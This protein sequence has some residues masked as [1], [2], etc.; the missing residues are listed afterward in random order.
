MGSISTTILG[1][2]LLI[3]SSFASMFIL[4]AQGQAL[5][6]SQKDGPFP[7]ASGLPE[8][9]NLTSKDPTTGEQFSLRAAV[10]DPDGVVNVSAEYWFGTGARTNSSM[11][12]LPNNQYSLWISIP[13]GSVEP[14]HY[15]F[16]ANDSLGNWNRSSESVV[17]VTDNDDPVFGSDYSDTDPSTGDDLDLL[18]EITDN[19]GVTAAAVEYWF[20]SGSHVNV[21]LSNIGGNLWGRTVVIAPAAES[22][23]YRFHAFD[24]ADN[25]A[26]TTVISIA[27]TD[28]DRPVFTDISLIS[29]VGTGDTVNIT[30]EISENIG[31]DDVSLEYWFGE[32]AHA[33]ETMIQGSDD[34]WYLL[35][36]AP[37]NALDDLNYTYHAVDLSDNYNYSGPYS[38]KVRDNDA[39]V[40]LNDMSDQ[41][42]TT[43]DPYDFEVKGR[44]NIGIA[45]ASASY[46][47]GSGNWTHVNLSD[48]MYENWT[49]TIV[50]P[51]GT[52]HPMEYFITLT[53]GSDN[54]VNS[55]AAFVPIADNDDPY[56]LEDATY[57]NAT[58]GEYFSFSVYI[59]DNIMVRSSFVEYWFGTGGHVIEPMVGMCQGPHL[60]F[61]IIPFNST[62]DLFYRFIFN[63][64]SNNT[65]VTSVKIVDVWDND[66][67]VF[68]PDMSGS[69][70][71]TGDEFP[72][73][74]TAMDNI[75][76]SGVAVEYGFGAGT[77]LNLSLSRTVG[78]GPWIGSIII[79]PNSL[80]KLR[81]RFHAED[82][83]GNHNMTGWF[84]RTVVDNDPPI[85]LLPSPIPKGTTGDMYK[86]TVEVSDNINI[87]EV[88]LE[89]WFGGGSR[90]NLSLAM[91]SGSVWTGQI[92]IPHTMERMKFTVHSWDTRGNKGEE[93]SGEVEIF[94]N[95]RP[96][97]VAENS[98]RKGTTGEIF[99]FRISAKDNIGIAMASVEYWIHMNDHRMIN[100][101]GTGTYQVTVGL[102]DN[103]TGI[104]HYIFHINDTSGNL[105]TS[106]EYSL[107]ITDNDPPVISDYHFEPD[108]AVMGG[109]IKISLNASDNIDVDTAV[110]FYR[111]GTGS[112]S[113]L[114]MER[115]EVQY[116]AFI[117][118]PDGIMMDL[119]L[120]MRITDRSGNGAETDWIN[121]KAEDR[122][123][124]SIENIDDVY[125]YLG[126][127]I[128][129]TAV[130]D[131]NHGVSRVTWVW[132]TSSHEGSVL[133][134]KPEGVINTTVVV[135]VFDLSGN[136]ASTGFGLIVWPVDRDA[137][138][139]GMP[140]LY[141]IRMG[142]DPW[143]ETDASGDPD[144]DNATNLEEYLSST[145]PWDGDSDNDGM[146]DG[147]ELK[148]GLDPLSDDAGL[149]PDGD[150]RSNLDE[151]LA[152]T[153]PHGYNPEE[154]E[155]NEEEDYLVLIIL[156]SIFLIFMIIGL[157]FYFREKPSEENMVSAEMLFDDDDTD[158]HAIGDD[159]DLDRDLEIIQEMGDMDIPDDAEADPVE[160]NGED[161]PEPPEE[162][163]DLD[164][165][166]LPEEEDDL[167]DMDL[168]E[169]ED[170][171]D[172]M[173]EIDDEMEEADTYP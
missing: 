155:G 101:S 18:V 90:E 38:I 173:D 104:L 99:T 65:V 78:K 86:F 120:M 74:V 170:D 42:G 47:F 51:P 28:N 71:T 140:D 156:V 158:Y 94:D 13:S 46:R 70:A 88:R 43:G 148:N 29:W 59:E 139:D 25:S 111:F 166:D 171:L 168:P 137:D 19:I 113:T 75:G 24:S 41:N 105:M 144:G 40:I 55:T 15:I 61:F 49:A 142:F 98:T 64:T 83:S 115:G 141:E 126:D 135:T 97:L 116:T 85:I 152:G 21:S 153:D 124:P 77:Y 117:D 132:D 66:L 107:N 100:M 160:I 20:G 30:A 93:V 37:D 68:G 96:V 3:S 11:S 1:A 23:R 138:G 32:S 69:N 130:V 134:I 129:L 17:S 92:P 12:P 84:V 27:V 91:G 36:A 102:P 73:N 8:I 146:D 110:V 133:N 22:L 125:M 150:G 121:I 167:D 159:E 6:G 123:P 7:S 172:D 165:M 72:F 147:W 149:D 67:P 80:D 44:D 119:V 54:H 169:E 53:D 14:L 63:D 62:D 50:I 112:I 39:P 103:M 79:P 114:I 81:Y 16:H 109:R 26:D 154:D 128:N 108:A 5:Y 95:D 106:S 131:D 164:D 136:T 127:S 76:I 34:S 89:Y 2:A 31:I 45:N 48:V 60:Y 10:T 145:D 56:V 35:V 118:V 9:T 33:N 151:Y 52:I 4:E 162:E 58:T 157:Y 163:D 57:D 122:T 82:P 161:E 87:H 143:D